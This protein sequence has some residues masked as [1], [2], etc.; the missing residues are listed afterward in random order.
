[1]SRLRVFKE[2]DPSAVLFESTDADAIIA[3]LSDH[4]VGFERWPVRAIDDNAGIE[5]ADEG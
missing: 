4:G 2:S 1:M 5:L 3:K